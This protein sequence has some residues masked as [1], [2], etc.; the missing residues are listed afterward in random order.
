MVADK[1]NWRT[2]LKGEVEILDMKA[3]RDELLD[4]LKVSLQTLSDQGV[5]MERLEA[6]VVEINY[7][8]LEYPT[9]ISSFNFDKNPV[10]EGTL[11]GIKG[12]YLIFDTG[13]I[14][15]RKF[16]AYDIE[17]QC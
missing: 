12:Q 14:N 1:T 11:M 16:T 9:K 7:P 8:V 2:M 5:G 3:R 6:D 17:V 13:V 15:L 4:R 10:V